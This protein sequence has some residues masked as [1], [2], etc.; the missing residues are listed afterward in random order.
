M[1]A[2]LLLV[3]FAPKLSAG[4]RLRPLP[5][6]H[7]RLPPT[8]CWLCRRMI[9]GD[10]VTGRVA[11]S[12]KSIAARD[13]ARSQYRDQTQR[14]PITCE[15]PM[16]KEQVKLRTFLFWTKI[17]AVLEICEFAQS[18]AK[19]S[20]LPA[21]AEHTWLRSRRKN[22]KITESLRLQYT[23]LVEHARRRDQQ[24]PLSILVVAGADFR[25]SSNP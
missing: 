25:M 6:C 13:S 10:R 7:I 11:S 5:R 18:G 24:I 1:R 4:V 3:K 14:I 17:I 15:R 9:A 21:L 23:G 2:L 8:R 22:R 19:T 16:P 20:T 12:S